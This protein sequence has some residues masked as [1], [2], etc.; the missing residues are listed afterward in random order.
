MSMGNRAT[1]LGAATKE[2]EGTERA[3]PRPL[4]SRDDTPAAQAL[5]DLARSPDGMVAAPYQSEFS[6]T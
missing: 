1:I 2:P 4:M 6:S 3:C 5:L